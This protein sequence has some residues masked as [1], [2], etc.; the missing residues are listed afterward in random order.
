MQR[1]AQGSGV[2]GGVLPELDGALE[3]PSPRHQHLLGP[4]KVTDAVTVVTVACTRVASAVWSNL[5]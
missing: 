4:K 3:G 1:H 2:D 5:F